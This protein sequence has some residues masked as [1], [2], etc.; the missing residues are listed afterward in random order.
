M[1]MTNSGRPLVPTTTGPDGACDFTD[2]DAGSYSLIAAGY[3]P[4]ATTVTAVA[5]PDNLVFK[6]TFHDLAHLHTFDIQLNERF[7]DAEIT[8]RKIVLQPV[9]LMSR[10]LGAEG[11]ARETLSP[12]IRTERSSRG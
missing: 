11:F 8:D 4:V 10:L 3:P 9:R 6:A 5:S 2:L 7:P 1:T 12:D